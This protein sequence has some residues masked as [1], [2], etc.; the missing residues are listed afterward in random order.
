MQ[1]WKRPQNLIAVTE[2]SDLDL[3]GLPGVAVPVKQ[4][5]LLPA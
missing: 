4:R 2:P 1:K 5:W 3:K